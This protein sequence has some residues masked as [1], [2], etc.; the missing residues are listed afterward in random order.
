MPAP[1]P[2]SLAAAVAAYAP[3]QHPTPAVID[4]RCAKGLQPRGYLLA[5]KRKRTAEE[6]DAM[7]DAAP[8]ATTTG[9]SGLPP[10][11]VR[12]KQDVTGLGKGSGRAWK[13]PAQRASALG[14]GP[15]LSTDWA[16]KMALKAQKAAFTAAKRAAVD[17]RRERLRDARRTRDAALTRKKAAQEAAAVTQTITKTST[18]KRMLKSRKQAKLLRKADTTK[19]G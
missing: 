18:V 9:A 12:A 13:E 4:F 2:T 1:P 6:E 3:P 7:V 15:T 19:V 8:T 14:R 10:R 11:R 5:R 17:G 16:T